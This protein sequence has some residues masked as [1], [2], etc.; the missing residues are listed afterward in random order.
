MDDLTEYLSLKSEI[1]S[2]KKRLKSAEAENSR[3]R[4]LCNLPRKKGLKK[5]AIMTLLAGGMEPKRIAATVP[6]SLSLV[7]EYKKALNKEG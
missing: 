4:G 6:C 1:E 5:S 3:L 2:L 7:Y